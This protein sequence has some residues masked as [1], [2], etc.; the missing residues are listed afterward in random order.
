MRKIHVSV[1]EKVELPC[2]VTTSMTNWDERSDTTR[3][4]PYPYDVLRDPSRKANGR[5][6]SERSYSASSASRNRIRHQNYG[7]EWHDREDT[8]SNRGSNDEGEEEK[9]EEGAYLVLWFVDTDRKPIY[10]F[11]FDS[12]L[13]LLL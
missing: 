4:S 11:L 1:G 10:R 3:P 7:A 13:S 9:D 6:A 5:S 12:L 2:D 8:E